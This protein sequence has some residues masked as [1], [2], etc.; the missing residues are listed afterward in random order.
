MKKFL[1][2]GFAV[3]VLSAVAVSSSVY[4]QMGKGG[5][6]GGGMGMGRGGQMANC[7]MG[8]GQGNG[9]G[10]GG[11]MG[12]GHGG[13][14]VYGGV[15]QN[16]PVI[17]QKDAEVKVNEYL[18]TFKGYKMKNVETFQGRMG[19]TGYIVNVVDGS[20]NKF[21]VRVSPHGYISGPIMNTYPNVK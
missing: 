9:C 4:A 18:K 10:Y 2:I 19:H 12:Y 8:Y 21:I 15:N 17:T 3:V 13:C 16:I 20:G 1:M 5:G 7:G 14:G 11:H 6:M